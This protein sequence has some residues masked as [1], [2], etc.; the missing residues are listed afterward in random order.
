MS[1]LREVDASFSFRTASNLRIQAYD[2]SAYLPA[3]VSQ[4][5]TLIFFDFGIN[6]LASTNAD[7]LRSDRA[8][9]G[10]GICEVPEAHLEINGHALAEE[11]RS[12]AAPRADSLPDCRDPGGLWWICGNRQD[13][14]RDRP[15]GGYPS[16]GN[17]KL[18]EEPGERLQALTLWFGS[19]H[20]LFSH[21]RSVP[22]SEV[23]GLKSGLPLRVL[24][25]CSPFD[26]PTNQ[27][28]SDADSS[29]TSRFYAD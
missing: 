22:A 18:H 16:Q 25:R 19:T 10:S 11:A 20:S 6:L 21:S 1:R 24:P 5:S 8:F 29:S 27:E 4:S 17:G 7:V 12:A 23:Q 15:Q 26:L 3:L 14:Q 13:Q 2:H 9:P 28:S